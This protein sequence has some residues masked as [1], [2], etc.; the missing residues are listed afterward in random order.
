MQGLQLTKGGFP[1]LHRGPFVE[2][3]VVYTL[4]HFEDWVA[5]TALKK[6]VVSEDV[7][8]MF[9][10]ERNNSELIQQ[11]D[12]NAVVSFLDLDIESDMSSSESESERSDNC[13]NGSSH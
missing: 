6:Y 1:V 12:L 9:P 10:K 4:S 13:E 2:A 8:A 5:P 11:K 7:L 3:L